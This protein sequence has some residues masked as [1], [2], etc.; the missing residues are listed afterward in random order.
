MWLVSFTLEC[1]S[2]GKQATAL[3]QLEKSGV[4]DLGPRFDVRWT[5]IERS[6]CVSMGLD[7]RTTHR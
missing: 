6:F 2:I 4:L 3:P 5:A 7:S 1:S